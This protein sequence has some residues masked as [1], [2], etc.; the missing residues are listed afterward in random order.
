MNL[1]MRLSALI[2]C[3]LLGTALPSPAHAGTELDR[4]P[5]IGDVAPAF[6]LEDVDGTTLALEDLRGRYVVIHFG[7]SW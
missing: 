3:S 5:W 7:T 4:H 6:A 2:L 1:Q